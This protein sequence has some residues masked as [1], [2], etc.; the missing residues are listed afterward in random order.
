[1]KL[2]NVHGDPIFTKIN[3]YKKQYEYL[4]KD[5]DTEV[6]IVGGGV[7]GSIVGYYFSKNNI[8]AVIL[9]K[10]RIAHG[11]TSI[12]TSFLQYELDSNAKEL[13]EYTCIDNVIISYK[14]GLK[15]LDELDEFIKE[16]VNKCKDERKD[17]LLYISKKYEVGEMKEEYEISV[18][19]LKNIYMD[20]KE[21]L[22]SLLSKILPH[23]VV[24]EQGTGY[25]VDCL[26]SSFKVIKESNSYE[27]TIKKAI[28][29]GN[30]TDTTAAVA[31]GIAGALYGFEN[32]PKKWFENLRG[33]DEVYEL[34]NKIDFKSEKLS[35]RVE[36]I[37][38]D[39][40]Q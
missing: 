11:S 29:L 23:D 12:T 22:E 15:A 35:E 25:V 27:E 20:K 10:E 4:T 16:Y 37:N 34:I 8:P 7:T 36:I 17:T 33:K 39:I 38:E 9:E 40:K 28:A 6:I 18:N 13:E 2:Q 30:D 1:M 5:I 14:L 26:K 21:Y 32:I 31:G 3:K 19:K 24:K